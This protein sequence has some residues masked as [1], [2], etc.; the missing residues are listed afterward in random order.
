LSG[1]GSTFT[2][3]ARVGRHAG[4]HRGQGAG[5]GTTLLVAQFWAGK[6]WRLRLRSDR[7]QR[8]LAANENHRL[9]RVLAA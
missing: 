8:L 7:E 3:A 9:A 6:D 5:L 1:R 4:L 2:D